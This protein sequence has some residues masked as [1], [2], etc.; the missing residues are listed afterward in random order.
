MSFMSTG[1]LPLSAY[2]NVHNASDHMCLCGGK[3][4]TL[5]FYMTKPHTVHDIQHID[6]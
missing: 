1:S 3:I 6:P 5:Q 2:L 4:T